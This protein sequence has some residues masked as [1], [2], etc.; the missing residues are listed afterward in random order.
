MRE[1]KLA[2]PE[3][4]VRLAGVLD[5]RPTLKGLR[6]SRLSAAALAQC[7]DPALPWAASIPSGARLEMVTDTT[8]IELDVQLMRL[9]MAGLPVAPAAFD[10]V[11]DGSL[12]ATRYSATGHVMRSESRDIT[13][14]ELVRGGPDTVRFEGLDASTKRVELWLPHNASVE[15]R[16]L[17]VG[18]EATVQPADPRER[19]WVHYGSSI[20][21]CLEAK[22]PTGTWPAVAARQA[23]VDLISLGFAGQAHLDQVVARTIRD[24]RADFISLKVGINVV[25]GDTMRERTF[26]PALEGFLDTVRDGHPETPLVVITPITCPMVEEHPGPTLTGPDGRFYVVERPEELATGALSLIRIRELIAAVV[27][28]RQSAGDLNLHLLHGPDLFGADDLAD[29]PDGLHPN[30]AGYRRMGERFHGAVFGG[31]GAFSSA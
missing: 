26:A 31:T 22:Q 1:L 3:R 10:L 18:A 17:R 8:E 30:P 19:T 13:Q 7:L 27:G 28:R 4:P 25:N 23:G 15:L 21:H 29:L 11:V 16:G 5:A 20:S 6:L 24:L 9:S 14:L 2:D 12:R